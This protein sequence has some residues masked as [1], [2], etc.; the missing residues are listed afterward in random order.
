MAKM[1]GVPVEQQI[2]EKLHRL[3]DAQKRRVL[4]F[5][6]ALQQTPARPA[7]DLLRLPPEERELLVAAAFEA[8]AGEDFE[9][10]E[11]YSEEEPDA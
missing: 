8:A 1:A 5:V 6:T 4:E 3:D 2:V 11:A 10:F 7:R 9:V